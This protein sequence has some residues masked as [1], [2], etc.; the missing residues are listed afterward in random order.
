MRFGLLALT[1]LGCDGALESLDTDSGIDTDQASDTDIDS[2]SE[3]DLVVYRDADGDGFGVG[4]DRIEDACEL[5][6][7]YSLRDGDCDDVAADVNPE[8]DEV[9]GDG[10]D[11]NCDG[12]APLCRLEG[13]NAGSDVASVLVGRNT[14]Q[15]FG[16]SA[17]I[18]PDLDGDGRDELVIGRPLD[19]RYRTGNGWVGLFMG[20]DRNLDDEVPDATFRRRGANEGLGETV[21]ALDLLGGPKADLVLAAPRAERG[22]SEDVGAVHIIEDAGPGA[23]LDLTGKPGIVW[24]GSARKD[25]AGRS[26][27]APGDVDGDGVVDLAIGAP[28]ATQGKSGKVYVVS[29]AGGDLESD[30]HTVIA[31][32]SAI[33]RTGELLAAVGDIDGDGRGDLVAGAGS[34]TDLST[35][36]YLFTDLE[37]GSYTTADA[38]SVLEGGTKVTLRKGTVSTAGDVDDDGYDDLWVGAPAYG[39]PDSTTGQVFLFLGSD[40]IESWSLGSAH[41]VLNGDQERGYLGSTVLGGEDWDRD[42]VPDLVTTAMPI[43]GEASVMVLYGLVEGEVSG[44]DARLNAGE[45]DARYGEFLAG[46][47]DLDGDGLSDLLIGSPG[48]SSDKGRVHVVWGLAGF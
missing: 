14:G 21:L 35:T 11:N 2:D 31:G 30:A 20:V 6:E 36:L 47:G 17:A 4:D 38:T 26:V 22:S 16:N 28:Q 24:R 34:R 42:G 1:L 8:A 9:C 48:Y 10:V 5:P 13:A 12:L 40:I 43:G 41:A 23:E 45:D 18:V 25:Q 29:G 3:C 7:G 37:Q 32:E 15:A 39:D 46:G 27:V 33:Q 19:T 44:P